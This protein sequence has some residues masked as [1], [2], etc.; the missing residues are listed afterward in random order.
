LLI[1]VAADRSA[2]GATARSTITAIFTGRRACGTGAG[3]GDRFHGTNRGIHATF[4]E[5][6][7]NGVAAGAFLTKVKRVRWQMKCA[8]GMGTNLLV[9]DNNLHGTAFF[10]KHERFHTVKR[11]AF[12]AMAVDFAH[13]VADMQPPA[14]HGRRFGQN[15]GDEES[16]VAIGFQ[17][18]A[19]A[20]L[21]I[22]GRK[23]RWNAAFCR[24]RAA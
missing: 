15:L 19:N 23:L 20:T 8:S 6:T 22:F 2:V 4:D 18:K 21:P 3:G 13:A 9:S 5:A 12:D 10:S 7:K 16:F 14:L 1:S 24:R 17:G 11:H